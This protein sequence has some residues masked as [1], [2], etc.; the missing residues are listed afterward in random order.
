MGTA[1]TQTP[2]V[3]VSGPRGV[4]PMTAVMIDER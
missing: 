4:M 3:E 2:N 1:A